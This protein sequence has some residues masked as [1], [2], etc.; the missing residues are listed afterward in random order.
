MTARAGSAA[1][2]SPASIVTVL[3]A[4][5]VVVAFAV[6]GARWAGAGVVDP[7]VL[8]TFGVLIAVGEFLRFTLPGGRDAAPIGTAMG[9]AMALVPDVGGAV[10]TFDAAVVVVVVTL[11]TAVGLGPH[12]LAGRAPR[13]DVLSRRLLAVALAALVFRGIDWP[14]VGTLVDLAPALDSHRYLMALVLLAVAILAAGFDVAVAAVVRAGNDNAPLRPALV[15]EVRAGLGISAAIGATGVLIALAA[16]PMDLIALPVFAVPLLITQFA[17]RR[18]AMVRST[19]RQT[20]RSLSRLTEIGGYTETRHST[21]VGGLAVAMGRDLG[22]TEG[23]LLELEYAALLHDIGQLSLTDPIPGGATVVA[24]AVDQRRIAELGAGIVR[25][26]GVLDQVATIVERQAD[27]YRR[28][29]LHDATG[30]DQVPLASRI[31]KVANAYDD[32]V[33][34]SP[35]LSRQSEALERIH[36]GMAFEYDPKVV[37]ALTRVLARLSPE[38]ARG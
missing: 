2:T 9:L 27:P 20:I 19:Y 14:A 29:R 22:L 4:L 21:R 12:A 34:E 38:P 1:G 37:T 24:A 32:L 7:W 13:L 30:D 18:Y 28:A 10:T 16:R 17:F 8:L 33:G 31:I 36:L 5:V 26:T 11:G 6:T 15:D 25:Q 3:G 23:D 35:L